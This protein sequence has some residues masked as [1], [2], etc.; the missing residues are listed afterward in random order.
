M[1]VRS[2]MPWAAT[3]GSEDGNKLVMM[4]GRGVA[5]CGNPAGGVA[6]LL[7]NWV[8]CDG[9]VHNRRRPSLVIQTNRSMVRDHAAETSPTVRL[10]AASKRHACS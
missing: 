5:G 3:D 2:D 8:A 6:F 10:S 9:Y 4:G 7:A 1:T